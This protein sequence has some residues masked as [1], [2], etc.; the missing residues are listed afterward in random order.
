MARISL[1]TY[2][3]EIEDLIDHGREDQAIAHCLHI[4]KFYP[5]HI[6]T[7]RQLGKAY[8]E[9][10]RYSD[11][12][13]ILQRVLSSFPDDFVS[14]V[15]MSIIR[16][17]EGNLDAAIWHMERAFDSQPANN[18]IQAELR[19]L[20]GRR[21]GVEPPN[22]RLTRGAL[23]RM[24]IKGNLYPQAVAEL[25]LAL[26]EDPERL[27]LQVLLAQTYHLSGQ[28]VEAV[29]TCS[30]LLHK[31]PYCLEANRILAEILADSERADETKAY[32]QRVQVLD[33][34][35]AHVSPSALT[36]EKVPDAAV[37]IE[38][39]EWRPGQ[40]ISPIPTQ[41]EWAASL[42]VELE[43]TAPEDEEI[44]EWLT[45]TLE[46][47]TSPKPESK[48]DAKETP[49]DEPGIPSDVEET[50]ESGQ[51][52]PPS[53]LPEWM[54]DAGWEP[55]SISDE[56]P[57]PEGDLREI[58]TSAEDLA[59]AEIP[60]WLR[61]M[62]PPKTQDLVEEME[63]P[64][65]EDTAEDVLPWL[66]K[67]APGPT[68]S[69][70]TWLEG[71]ETK[72]LD[73]A[74]GA[75]PEWL[76]SVDIESETT[77]PAEPSTTEP[78]EEISELTEELEHQ[79]DDG[80]IAEA[81]EIPEWLTESQP[82][83]VTE[84]FA[85]GSTETPSDI[86]DWLSDIEEEKET[87]L[88]AEVTSPEPEIEA[89]PTSKSAEIPEWLEESAIEPEAETPP[90]EPS[91]EPADLPDWLDDTP[92]SEAVQSR[93]LKTEG[94]PETTDLEED[95]ALS[96]LED[97]PAKQGTEPSLTDRAE[98]PTDTA[99]IPGWLL[100]GESTGE[101]EA[102]S[103]VGDSEQMPAEKTAEE[104]T[105]AAE[106]GWFKDLI[107]QTQD[108][109]EIQPA[110]PTQELID[111][112]VDIELPDWL[113]GSV[114]DEEFETVIAQEE[115][116]SIADIGEISA[117]KSEQ[118]IEY[119][120]GPIIEDDTQPTRIAP[121]D[122]VP[123]PSLEIE[124][125]VPE[126]VEI[127]A[128]EAEIT[129]WLAEDVTIMQEGE[130]VAETPAEELVEIPEWLGDV[131]DEI[132]SIETESI[133]EE[134]SSMGTVEPAEV[135]APPD[136]PT[137]KVLIETPPGEEEA[138]QGVDDEEAA[139]AW[140]ESL[141]VKQGADEALLLSPE[142]RLE[143]PPDWVQEAVTEAEEEPSPVAPDEPAETHVAP[144]IL[145]ADAEAPVE[146]PTEE[147]PAD[148]SSDGDDAAFAWLESLAVKQGA[149]EAPLLEPEERL[150]TPPD[151]IQ[152]AVPEVEV[153]LSPE[154][155][156]EPTEAQLAT[157]LAEAEAEAPVEEPVEVPEWLQDLVEE[158]SVDEEITTSTETTKPFEASEP[159]LE[160]EIP[161]EFTVDEEPA[162]ELEEIVPVAT[163]VQADVKDIPET[164]P[165]V[166]EIDEAQITEEGKKP[167]R[168][169][170]VVAA[171]ETEIEESKEPEKQVTPL[172]AIEVESAEAP[173]PPP[174]DINEAVLNELEKLPGI[175]F[176]K[177][178]AILAYRETSGQFSRIEDLQNVSG[179]GP[180]I[181]EEVKDLVNVGDL[182][183]EV[184]P[185]PV[186]EYQEALIQARNSLNQEN[187]TEA[188][189]HYLTLIKSRR[190]LQEVIEDLTEALYLYPVDV[191]IWQALGDAYVRTGQLQE[192]LD[193]YTKAEEM[194]R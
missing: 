29:E 32:Q 34:Y 121:L 110:Q 183:E 60:D 132:T 62:A 185:E 8:L 52:S 156:T 107:P 158:P 192:A 81:L 77:T 126:T 95:A 179:V 157:E 66:E 76:Q 160:P 54:E 154:A 115:T 19:R 155:P 111:E 151:W 140:L 67:A 178:Q 36:P 187:V 83:Q 78:E 153:G 49:I 93:E 167:A 13:D 162:T 130:E 58:D 2:N 138:V 100:E 175:G 171:S 129:E 168:T 23:S 169:P 182:D 184:T 122:E 103:P 141:A 139:F 10:Q 44:P 165:R 172:E 131:D 48:M 72:P 134:P 163:P 69:I 143:T 25:R 124:P 190:L 57:S 96:W 176:V 37:G 147:P 144:T 137:T 17:D 31:L 33:P 4:I 105:E 135:T 21:D 193:T 75:I 56:E 133:E 94:I 42:G 47:R 191:Y 101:I 181:M 174:L 91:A 85:E 166:S 70:I 194:I 84:E 20:Y 64:A 86:P 114:I 71:K 11:A 5:K 53:E 14:H 55:A 148:P 146:A 99:A 80:S 40:T 98:D 45:S 63:T 22:V 18:A 87:G 127:G 24:Y 149:D 41:P 150:E 89:E 188:L 15:G 119:D 104:P 61:S 1:R 73:G 90:I 6:D 180:S 82:P 118:I 102:S 35:A 88:D 164:P 79:P 123:I 28:N 113:N 38:R 170:L 186:D 116:P 12:A 106:P 65:S 74:P 177:A 173:L 109:S 136:E 97:L 3:R 108:E 112:T 120:E 7:Y 27:D 26:A 92:A 128:E 189:D 142:E 50:G 30:A 145:E 46:E 39:L 125:D 68:D 161:V 43:G 159:V 16:E 51:P 59:P 117:D 152:E 9:G